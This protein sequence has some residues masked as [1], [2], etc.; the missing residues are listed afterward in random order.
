MSIPEKNP[1]IGAVAYSK[2]NMM[3][4]ARASTGNEASNSSTAGCASFSN[5][6]RWMLFNIVFKYI[7]TFLILTNTV[8]AQTQECQIGQGKEA[9]VSCLTKQAERS[10][11]VEDI[12]LIAAIYTADKEYKEAIK[13]YKKSAIK[14]DAK[15]AFFLGGIYDEALGLESDKFSDKVKTYLLGK[16]EK[17]MANQ[18][19]AIKWYKQAA[20]A[21]YDDAMPHMNEMM[22]KVYGKDGAVKLYQKEIQEGKDLYWNKRFLANFYFRIDAYE[23]RIAVYNELIK[24]YPDKQGDWLVSIGNTYMKDYLNDR[25]KEMKYYRE[26]AKCGNVMA[27]HNLGIYYGNKKEY[28][29]AEMWFKKAGDNSMVC[30]MYQEVLKDKERALECYEDQVVESEG[31]SLATLAYVYHKYKEYD[32]ALAWYKKAVNLGES[33]AALNIAVIYDYRLVD[34][35]KMMYWYKKAASMGNLK[36]IKFLNKKGEL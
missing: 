19:E 33:G 2:S 1:S 5:K 23:K 15:A 10:K 18:K 22:E 24:E 7:L 32:K 16:D 8:I 31:K 17:L 11:A 9:F 14:G 25:E 34:K 3:F 20:K 30:F 21:N 6:N 27:M 29:T 13:W 26:A 12:N 35:E 36:A 28:E 4:I